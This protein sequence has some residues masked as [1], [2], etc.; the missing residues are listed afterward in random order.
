MNLG[1]L[2]FRIRISITGF[3]KFCIHLLG[4]ILVGP[5][6]RYRHPATVSPK[7][8]RLGILYI[9]LA[10]RGDLILNFPAIKAIKRAY[11][12]SSITCWVREYNEDLAALNRNIDNV[13]TYDKF[14]SSGIGFLLRPLTIGKHRPFIDK[15]R[16][17]RFDICVDDSGYAFTSVVGFLAG[18]PYRVGRNG[19][20]F[21]FLYHYEYPYD[22]NAQLIE[23]R[24][25]LLEP[26]GIVIDN[27]DDLYPSISLGPDLLP[28][29]MEKCGL[30]TD[31]S[32][33]VT[34]QPFGGWAAKNW[35]IDKFAQV[36][37]HFV[38]ATKNIPVFIGGPEDVAGISSMAAAVKAR[39]INTA[40]TLTVAESA[41]LISGARLHLGVDSFGAHF[42]AAVGVAGLTIF[43]P[44]N[45]ELSAY[46]GPR[47]V[48]VIK[49][50]KCTPPANRIYCCPDAGRSCKRLSCMR[51]LQAEDVSKVLM[52]LWE[53]KQA[54][55]VTAF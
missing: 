18:I 11:P 8:A 49:K 28:P 30:N 22:F 3:I 34:I 42:A 38:S 15:I 43:G 40:G 33:Y 5:F 53:G 31:Q 39:S 1:L 35:D 54:V 4:A 21:G 19:Q 47:N 26:L 2:K 44:T 55:R 41:I 37:D 6:V 25:R 29:V 7:S 20:G 46:L 45:P 51:E 52:T 13:I 36:V 10:F 12:Q 17:M 9:C 23:K 16:R 14:P 27:P 24:L 32:N 48:A 50:T